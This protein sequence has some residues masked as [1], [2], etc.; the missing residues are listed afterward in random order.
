MR[1]DKDGV[2][3]SI[4]DGRSAVAWNA[5]ERAP[6]PLNGPGSRRRKEALTG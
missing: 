3:P 6:K 2:S 4:K 1:L 5:L